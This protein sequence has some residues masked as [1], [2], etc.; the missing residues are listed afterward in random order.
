MSV[1][2]DFWGSVLRILF[3]GDE[4]SLPSDLVDYVAD[5]GDQW[6]AQQV[7]DGNSA[8]EA[9][10]LSPFDAVIVAP[11]LPDLTAATLLGQ[12]RTLRPDTIRIALIDAQGGQRTPPARIIGVAHRFLPMPLAPEVLLEAVTSLEELRELL[13]NPRLRAAIGRIEKLPSPP[14]LY[15]SLMHALEEDDGADAADISKLIAGDPA[16]A[17][18]VLQLCNSAFFSGGRSITDLRTAVTRLGVATLRDLVLAS[19]VFSVQTLTPAE[20]NAMQ[21]RAL[22]SS[23]LAAKVLPPTSAEL[24]STAA[25]LADIGLLLPGVR[26]EREAP[27]EA[28]DER[29]GHTEAGAYLLGLW[30]L[31][32]PIIEAVAFHRHPLRSSMRS[33]WV[34]GAVHV[35]TALASGESVDEEYL[36]KVGVI[37]RLPSWREQADTLLGLTEA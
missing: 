20:R 12:I 8:I 1:T 3:V 27:A 24:G 22:L 31:P 37:A 26:D 14:H 34:T 19:E 9:A 5:L 35:A 21:R 33:F 17:A 11:V 4:A 25:L 18:K 6:Q 30:G 7:A 13:S 2:G 29:L 36:T 28:G 15:L 16:I 23:R 32:M 10:A